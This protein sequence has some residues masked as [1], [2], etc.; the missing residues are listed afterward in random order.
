MKKGLFIL[1][2]SLL[3]M[4]HFV[5]YAQEGCTIK[6]R[7]C[8]KDGEPLIGADIR[9]N[10]TGNFTS[11]DIDGKFILEM[12]DSKS[13]VKI[14]SIGFKTMYLPSD[15]DFSN[16]IAVKDYKDR[17][18]HI[19]LG[20]SSYTLVPAGDYN[21]P[22]LKTTYSAG[23][24]FGKTFF[25]KSKPGLQKVK[26]GVMFDFA[27]LNYNCY[28]LEENYYWGSVNES[29]IEQTE[30]GIQIGPAMVYSPARNL[31]IQLYAQYA[32]SFGLLLFDTYNEYSEFTG[33][34]NGAAAG[35]SISYGFIGVGVEYRYISTKFSDDKT[36]I[37]LSKPQKEEDIMLS[38]KIGV[39]G[40]NICNN[41]LRAYLTFKF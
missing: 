6:G 32:P 25:F 1:F 27:N 30:L 7:I 3:C 2:F 41:G 31:N 26:Y 19:N 28:E 40:N 38:T 11:T 35:F 24:S 12:N 22:D 8:T 13:S 34:S 36:D 14:S 18:F 17:S 10:G 5:A 39:I 9:E 20:A 23:F 37:S 4:I 29:Y 33:F 21:I 16:I 15:F